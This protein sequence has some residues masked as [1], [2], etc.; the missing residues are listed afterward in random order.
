MPT[1]DRYEELQAYLRG[2]TNFGGDPLPYDFIGTVQLLLALLDN[3]RANAL[4][5][6]LEDIGESLSEE[7]TAF[8]LKLAEYLRRRDGTA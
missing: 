6:E 8:F 5:A 1:F 2:F 4:E 7:Q 3:L